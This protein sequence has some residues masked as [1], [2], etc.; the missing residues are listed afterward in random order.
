MF[1]WNVNELE[2]IMWIKTIFQASK[3]MKLKIYTWIV[4]IR[5]KKVLQIVAYPR[6]TNVSSRYRIKYE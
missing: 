1:I 5:N 2:I 3:F 6:D 4:E